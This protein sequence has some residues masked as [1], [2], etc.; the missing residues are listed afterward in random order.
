MGLLR[1]F[2]RSR[3]DAEVAREIASYIEIETDA[4]IARGLAPADAHAAAAR[5]FGN[6]TRIREQVYVMNTIGPVDSLWQDLRYG[7]R[8]LRRDTGFAV[9]AILS[10]AL[11]IGANSA[12][13]QLLDTVRL[14]SLP[15]ERPEELVEIRLPPGPRIGSFN[16]RHPRF[17]YAQWQHLQQQQQGFTGLL[18][19]SSQ[20]FNTSPGGEVRNIE[21]L[22]VSGDFF[23][24]LGVTPVIGRLL[25]ARDDVRGCAPGVVLSHAYWQ[26]EFGGQATVLRQR[27]LLNG[28]SFEVIGVVAPSFF[29]LDVGRRFDI[30]LPLCADAMFRPANSRLDQ[31]DAW[32]LG[33]FGRIAPGRTIDEVQSHLATISPAVF[34]AT[35]P[36][37]YMPDDATAYRA[38]KW[39]AVPA[40]A[41]VS[42]LRSDFAQPLT[43]L[44][45]ITALVLVI[46]CANLANLLLARASVREREIALR[47]AIGAARGRIVRQL[48]IES[49]LLASVGAAIGAVL[50]AM[51]SRVLVSVLA[52]GYVSL[53][54]DLSWNW[55]MLV[56]TT[57]VA[58]LA[59]LLF[60]VVPALRATAVSPGAALKSGG[61]AMTRGRE[62]F[63]LR[64]GLVVTQ[65]AL[66]LVLL[67]GALLFTRT[68]YNLL[69]ERVG[70]NTALVVVTMSHASL[71]A[72]GQPAQQRRSELRER[73]AQLPDVVAV[74]QADVVPLA[75]T[76][77]WNE[78]VR[79]EGGPDG[80]GAD[81]IANFNRVSGEYFDVLELP[82][83]AGRTFSPSD[84]LHAP[85][86]AI[87]NRTFV[88]RFVPDGQPLGRR[89][90]MD[91]PPGA[92]P[93]VFEVVG[94][95]G[96]SKL[97]DVRD[98]FEAIVYVASTQEQEP[99]RV[100]Q[101]V[102]QPR[103]HADAAIQSITRAVAEVQPSMNIEFRLL[104]QTIRDSLVREQLMAALS[105]AFGVLAGL[106]AAIGLYGVM[107]Y[108]VA[109]RANEIGI[110]MAMGAERATVLRMIVGE[111]ST[112]I[113]SGIVI[114]TALAIAAAH[115]ARS[116][117]YGLQPS[118]PATI[119]GAIVLL[120]A[121]GLLA[122]F[123]PARRASRLDPGIAL[124]D[125]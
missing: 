87:V 113:A 101:Y 98:E 30:A 20:L 34:N 90:T 108:S 66:S 89:I 28:L 92:P 121:I 75:G 14:R 70:F 78:T 51:L 86:V 95:T 32:W 74:A 91:T 117:L 96:D 7:A 19:W 80:P 122:G 81:R 37:S 120:T 1:Y 16:G 39:I 105:A 68:F 69:S 52:T 72:I 22:W 44:L 85:A 17:T 6:A 8:L 99:G 57:G 109:R 107:S 110:R 119:G 49:I 21:G 115:A 43:L 50:A 116:L 112:L 93:A 106:L 18:A 41:G 61:R 125:E 23:S 3:H 35:V 94:V 38:N 83:L 9:A 4:N 33:V 84:D 71:P 25:T 11:G 12:I 45:A 53:F 55:R 60:G 103:G 5:K 59:C 111:A 24:V 10:L 88:R 36:P 40:A 82:L 15:V 104:Q 56:F 100:I 124:R 54:V 67:V 64:R 97:Q 58:L 123:V 47:L 118:D 46:A 29:G 62:R 48:L 76:G 114:G 102:V 2:R 42:G 77:L 65:V 26:R 73:M 27:V 13:F 63:A 79:V 31:L